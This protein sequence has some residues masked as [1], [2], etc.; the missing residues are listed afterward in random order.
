MVKLLPLWL[1]LCTLPGAALARIDS[2]VDRPRLYQQ[3]SVLLT[4]TADEQLEVSALDIR[5][6][7]QQFV[8]GELRFAQ[9]NRNGRVIS[10]WQIPLLPLAAGPQQIPSLSVAGKPSPVV[11]LSVQSGRPAQTMPQLLD[12]RLDRPGIYP[13]QAALYQ[14]ELTLPVGIQIDSVTPPTL[15]G[16]RIRQIG[17]DR[18]DE[19]MEDGKRIRTLHRSYAITHSRPGTYQLQGPLVQG[20]TLGSNVHRPFLQ[21]GQP[22]SLQIMP[23]PDGSKPELVSQKIQLEAQW[24]TGSGPYRVGDPLVRLLTIRAFGNTLEQFPPLP[25]PELTGVRSYADGKSQSETIRQG[26]L[27]AEQTLRQAF[28]PQQPGP[29]A[30]PPITLHWW[31]SQR[32]QMETTR[33]AMPPLTIEAAVAPTS[34]PLPAP[35]ADENALPWLT[36]GF[37][38]AW[39]LTLL[40]WWRSGRRLPK[41]PHLH[42]LSDRWSWRQL[43]R[44]LDTQDPQQIHRALLHWGHQRWPQL[45]P[46]CL[47]ALPCYPD[48]RAELDP[49]LAACFSGQAATWSATNLRRE[50]SRWREKHPKTAQ[51]LNPDGLI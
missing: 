34:S 27:V 2:Q 1:C 46:T 21:Q 19:T 18:L 7:F 44:A 45:Q 23:L 30:L 40:F 14:L 6:L 29:L 15:D 41:L 12:V 17:D 31:N 33:L 48:L 32:Q 25:L 9:S 11:A 20:L 42:R 24:Q 47:E 39:V 35:A 51:P 5:P 3:Q 49:L 50:L 22:L 38:L 37:A 10:Q 43:K 36:L 16:A 8:V 28:I 13:G 4:I 26:Q